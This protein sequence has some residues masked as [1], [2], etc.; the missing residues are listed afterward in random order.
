MND[1]TN[2]GPGQ[3]RA[4]ES[5][6]NPAGAGG[7]ADKPQDKG[8]TGSQGPVEDVPNPSPS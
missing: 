5:P 1:E 6:R 2:P 3:D 4:T 7:A 8:M